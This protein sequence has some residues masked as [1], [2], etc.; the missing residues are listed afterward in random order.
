M[1][2]TSLQNASLLALLLCLPGT[3]LALQ[4]DREQPVHVVSDEQLADLKANLLIFKGN[5]IGT[6]GSIIIHADKVEVRR[7]ENDELKSIIGYG[8]PATFEQTMD[9]GKVVNSNSSVI[10]YLPQSNDVILQG[11]AVIWQGS[12][13]LTGERVIYNT[14]TERMKATNTVDPGNR[15]QSTFIP[16]EMRKDKGQDK[17]QGKQQP[18]APKAGPAAAPGSKAPATA[19]PGGRQG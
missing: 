9:D 4:S 16:A 5:V 8:A 3:A 12:S 15:V 10:T 14:L 19:G 2:F 7:D 1:R 6:Q 13:R 11:K 18:A 17:G